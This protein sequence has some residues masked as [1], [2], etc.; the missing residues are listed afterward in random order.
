VHEERWDFRRALVRAGVFVGNGLLDGSPQLDLYQWNVRGRDSRPKDGPLYV[1]F[2]MGGLPGTEL[3]IDADIAPGGC[4][5][6]NSLLE[7]GVGI[8]AKK[9]VPDKLGQIKTTI[10]LPPE[11]D[12]LYVYCQLKTEPTH[13][14]HVLRRFELQNSGFSPGSHPE[15]RPQAFTLDLSE[16]KRATHLEVFGGEHV[17]ERV[18]RLSPGEITTVSWD[19]EYSAQNRDL[20]LVIIGIAVAVA[21]GALIEWIRPRIDAV[22]AWGEKK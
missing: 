5:E 17:S 14:S 7:L 2:H 4:D 16:M 15:Y 9:H 3:L 13:I 22:R 21:A 8:Q 19:D 11:P 1:L 12:T 18:R 10:R 6:A 20:R